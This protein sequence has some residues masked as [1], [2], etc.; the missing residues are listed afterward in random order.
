MPAY[1]N[2][3]SIEK[4]LAAHENSENELDRKFHEVQPEHATGGECVKGS[5]SK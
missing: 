2:Q 3:N 5:F 1:E 4:K